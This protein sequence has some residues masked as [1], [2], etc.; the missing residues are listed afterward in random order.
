VVDRQAGD[1]SSYSVSP[2]RP[3]K[4]AL[5]DSEKVEALADTLET[6]FQSMG[7][8]SVPAVIEMVHVALRSYFQTSASELKLTNPDE[9]YEIIRG[10]KVGKA[11]GRN[12]TPKRAFKHLPQRA[13]SY[14]VRIFN[15]IFLTHHFPSLWKPARVTYILKPGNAIG[16]LFE[17][18]LLARVLHEVRERGIMRDE[19]FV[20]RPRHSTSLQLDRLVERITM[21]FGEKRLT[22]A[23]FL[24][25]A[26]AFDTVWI[27]GLLYKLTLLN[28]PSYTVH[29][30][31]SYLRDRTLEASF[32]TATSFR[33]GIKFGVSQ[34][35]LISPI[36]FKSVCQRHGFT[37]AP[38][39]VSSLRGLY[40]HH[41]HFPQADAAHQL[42]EVIPQRP[43][44]VVEGMG[45][46]H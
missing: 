18:I 16:T 33:R 23:V 25:V 6:Q 4:I 38:R 14:L 8:P 46:R 12:G 15:A 11:S 37:L 44:T 26:K 36:L 3:G 29:T 10:L 20:F 39:R 31:S 2:D 9:V 19:Q 41:S 24:D 22:G 27:D 42:P 32:Q 34:G 28:F 43:S 17:K 40:G 45:N 21:N 13:V 7:D 5:S 30:I 35:G 1:E